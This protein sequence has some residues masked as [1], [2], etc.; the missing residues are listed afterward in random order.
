M[1]DYLLFKLIFLIFYHF[2]NLR[3]CLV[4]AFQVCQNCILTTTPNTGRIIIQGLNVTNCASS[5][6]RVIL[7]KEFILPIVK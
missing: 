3:R 6:L 7:V 1:E 2:N 4:D 5:A